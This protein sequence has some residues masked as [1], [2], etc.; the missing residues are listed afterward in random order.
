MMNTDDEQ[1]WK[2]MK[3]Q[4]VLEMCWQKNLENTKNHEHDARDDAETE[5]NGR[6]KGRRG[7]ELSP[8]GVARDDLAP[9]VLSI[10]LLFL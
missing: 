6:E 3:I 1:C 4:V 7:G 10:A 9:L 8:S 5:K 2:M